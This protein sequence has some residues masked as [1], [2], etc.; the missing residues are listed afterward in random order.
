MSFPAVRMLRNRQTPHYRQFLTETTLTK[1]QL[2]FPLFINESLKDKKAVKKMSG[3]Y[4]QSPSSLIPEVERLAKLG[5]QSLIL[6]GIPVKKD[7]NGECAYD[8]K[9]VVQQA[10]REIKKHF[11]EML[12]IADCCLCEYTSHGHCGIMLHERLNN[13][14]TLRSLQ[15]IAVSYAEAGADIIAPSGMMDGMIQ[16]IRAGLDAKEFTMVPIMSYAAKFSS[17]FYEPFREAAGSESNFSGNRKHHQIAP[18]QKREALRDA[19]LDVDEGADFLMVKPAVH[20]LDI[21]KT[22]RDSTLLPITAY[23]TSGEYAML[24][25][26]LKEGLVRNEVE[27]FYET[28]VGIRRAGADHIITYYADEMVKHL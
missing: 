24:K 13:D 12:I 27:A 4:Q 2:I 11:P 16:A 23:H 10:I 17:Q 8:A 18:S 21:I 14:A 19:L 9:G 3:I 15:K 28:L 1:S 22:L 25:S 6:F 5:I 7:E 20:Y 26:A